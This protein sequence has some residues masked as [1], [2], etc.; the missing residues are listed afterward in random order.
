M[1]QTS[2]TTRRR[3][4]PS[5]K[6]AEMVEKT[7]E[8]LKNTPNAKILDV[9]QALGVTSR[10]VCRYFATLRK[11]GRLAGATRFRSE[12]EWVSVRNTDGG[13]V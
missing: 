3:G 6:F 2:V 5:G 11:D 4:R 10:Q 12:G 1:E 13:Q 8:F 9:A 7:H